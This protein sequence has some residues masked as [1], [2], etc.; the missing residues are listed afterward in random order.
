MCAALD[1]PNLH[2]EGAEIDIT[3]APFTLLF[4]LPVG[5][6]YGNYLAVLVQEW[7]KNVFSF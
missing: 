7:K 6:K 3:C 2:K 1:G 5:L 4:N